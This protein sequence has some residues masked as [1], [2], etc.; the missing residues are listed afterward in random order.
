MDKNHFESNQICLNT[1]L[2]KVFQLPE[3]Q[4]KLFYKQN[5]AGG[6]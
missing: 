1:N 6:S 4:A 5:W 3:F 2:D